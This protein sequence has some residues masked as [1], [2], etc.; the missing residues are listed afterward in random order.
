MLIFYISQSSEI[1]HIYTPRQTV[2]VVGGGYIVFHVVIPLVRTNV[3]GVGG[4]KRN[5]ITVYSVKNTSVS[6]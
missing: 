6:T 2:V 3:P 5:P 4:Q 1:I